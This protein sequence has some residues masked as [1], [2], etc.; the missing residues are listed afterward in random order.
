MADL[1]KAERTFYTIGDIEHG[2]T[3]FVDTIEE[4]A[5]PL[6]DIV[7]CMFGV[8]TPE[9]A[10]AVWDRDQPHFKHSPGRSRVLK[11]TISVEEIEVLAD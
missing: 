11:V 1:A 5:V 2:E 7:G 3:S 9:A 6:D 10:K 4:W 8:D